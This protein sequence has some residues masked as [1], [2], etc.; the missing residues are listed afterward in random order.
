ML[1]TGKELKEIGMLVEK[2]PEW[3]IDTY[4]TD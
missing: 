2:E 4:M 1:T 3:V